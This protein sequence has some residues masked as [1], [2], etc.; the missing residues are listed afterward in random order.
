MRRISKPRRLRTWARLSAKSASSST[1]S[2]RRGGA[3]L[4]SGVRSR[5]SDRLHEYAEDRA[6]IT[7]LTPRDRSGTRALVGKTD[8]DY[9]RPPAGRSIRV[10]ADARETFRRH[11]RGA[12][13]LEHLA[14]DLAGQRAQEL[15]G[16]GHRPRIVLRDE[17]AGVQARHRRGLADRPHL[18]PGR[19]LQEEDAHQRRAALRG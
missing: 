9:D 16:A 19:L 8:F 11:L 5:G 3:R 6:A 12:V 15:Q 10:P 7:P 4:T 1:T 13:K 18:Q 2:R 14:G 17:A